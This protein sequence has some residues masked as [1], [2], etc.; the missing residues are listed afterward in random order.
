M[1]KPEHLGQCARSPGTV[2]GT[3]TCRLHGGQVRRAPSS[4]ERRGRLSGAQMLV[5]SGQSDNP[6]VGHP[7]APHAQI[8]DAV[9]AERGFE[10]LGINERP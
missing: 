2:R 6:G 7:A 8:R 3:E 4:R 10:L 9:T 1:S 5:G